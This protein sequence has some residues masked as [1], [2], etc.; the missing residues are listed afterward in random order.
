M[1]EAPMDLDA[2][3]YTGFATSPFQGNVQLDRHHTEEGGWFFGA[4]GVHSTLTDD[5]F[6]DARDAS[7]AVWGVVWDGCYGGFV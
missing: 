5:A 4:N 1:G 2:L 3:K 6:D 7:S